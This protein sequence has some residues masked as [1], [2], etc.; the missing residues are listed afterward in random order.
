MA[1]DGRPRRRRPG[2]PRRA[3]LAYPS[4]A[5]VQPI[6]VFQAHDGKFVAQTD[7]FRAYRDLVDNTVKSA[8]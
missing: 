5:P 3:L 6:R 4:A 7:W 8:E 1:G 2:L